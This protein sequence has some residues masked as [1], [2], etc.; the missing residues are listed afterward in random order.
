MINW[1]RDTVKLIWFFLWFAFVI[2]LGYLLLLGFLWLFR[3]PA[4][5]QLKAGSTVAF[6]LLGRLET[7]VKAMGGLFLVTWVLGFL[8]RFLLRGRL[9]SGL[10]LVSG[11]SLPLLS[12]FTFPFIHG[13]YRHLRGNTPLLLLFGAVAILLLPSSLLLLVGFFIFLI[14][15]IGVWLFGARNAPT[16]GASGLVLGFYSFDVAHGL[17]AGGWMTAVAVGL[18]LFFGRRMFKTLISRGKT[19]EGANISMTAHL[20]GFLS[21]IF[22]AYMIS[23][24]GFVAVG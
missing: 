4:F 15:G 17:F 8:D 22:A 9:I 13:S 12:I 18:L 24:F 20:W 10:G 14:Q 16:V 1:V 5:V 2:L 7:A 21:G 6:D 19:A 3:H 23:P 11:G